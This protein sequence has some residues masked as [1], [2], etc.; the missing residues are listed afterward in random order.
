MESNMLKNAVESA[1]DYPD[2][3]KRGV[4]RRYNAGKTL[5]QFDGL[6]GASDYG[7]FSARPTRRVS[8]FL[9]P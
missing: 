2:T 9:L 7:R 1:A 4:C 8:Y 5:S 6:C 3:R